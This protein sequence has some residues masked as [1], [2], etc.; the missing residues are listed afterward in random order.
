MPPGS[1]G[2]K[3]TF[4]F[5]Y[6]G[7]WAEKDR[8]ND[9]T[10]FDLR[11][12]DADLGRWMVPDP[13]DQF[14]SPYLAMGNIPQQAIDPDGG[15]VPPS[16]V[17]A[18][19]ALRTTQSVVL[20]GAGLSFGASQALRTMAMLT[21]AA[22]GAYHA[23]NTGL[24][25]PEGFQIASSGGGPNNGGTPPRDQAP[26]GDNPYGSPNNEPIYTLEEFLDSYKSKTRNQIIWEQGRVEK[27]IGGRK[28]YLPL[29][30]EKRYVTDPLTK[31]TIDMRH[32]LVVGEWGNFPGLLVEIQ[33]WLNNE[34]SAFNRQDFFSNQLG[35][36]FY[37]SYPASSFKDPIQTNDF[38][39]KISNFLGNPRFRSK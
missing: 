38:A 25:A 34:P 10:E 19:A 35:E 17:G 13:Y 15:A 37:N 9:W 8:D 4:S 18:A 12:Y 14:H 20:K 23:Y 1:K 16:P 3:P 2:S 6:Q 31:K 5:G 22:S 27:N 7:E 28:I 11:H 21:S 36:L 30:P 24:Q 32:M 33:Q 26:A 39:L 29:G